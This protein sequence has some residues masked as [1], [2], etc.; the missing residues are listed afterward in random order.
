MRIFTEPKVILVARPALVQEGIT[1]VLAEYDAEPGDWNRGEG[2][3]SDGDGLAEFM[4]RMCYGS[5][6]DRQG[7]V[8]GQA[9]FENVLTGGHGSVLEHACWSFVVTRAS[10]GYTHQQ[11]RHRAGWAYSQESQH[12]IRY[13]ESDEPGSQEAGACLT[14]IPPELS[15]MVQD[16]VK[17]AM[18]T[19]EI[20]WAEIR[21]TFPPEAKAKKDVSG[22]ARALLPAILESRIGITANARA[23]RHFCELRGKRDNVLEIRLVAAQVARIMKQEAPAIFQDIEIGAADDGHPV[24]TSRWGKV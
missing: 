11:V 1:E 16:W 24:V 20:L 15:G 17:D 12:F 9:Y 5:F 8:G 10:R 18:L 4:G 14:G 13:S 23:L 3:L 19:Y 22:T 2:E 7:R 21:R 6:G